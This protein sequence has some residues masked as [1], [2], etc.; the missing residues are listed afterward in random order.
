VSLILEALRK[1]ERDR[2]AP[3]RGVVVMTA[4]GVERRSLP[5]GLWLA[6]GVAAGLAGAGAFAML[7]PAP[8][9]VPASATVPARAAAPPAA[10]VVAS[11]TVAPAPVQRA[12]PAPGAAPPLPAPPPAP[13][14][15]GVPTAPAAPSLV[16]Q[17]I[18][19]RDGQPV[20]LINDR[21]L[22]EGDAF[23]GVRIVRIGEAE[24]EVEARGV[25]TVLRF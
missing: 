17:A 19:T 3:E 14:S 5:A 23:D 25:R 10:P 9:A 8:V 20:A 15:A 16:L 7:R 6:A 22:R 11:P 12:G 1:L 4:A 13:E 21:L 2:P 24:V 18:T